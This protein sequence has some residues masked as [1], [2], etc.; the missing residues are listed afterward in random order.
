M[1][2]GINVFITFIFYLTI[3]NNKSYKKLTSKLTF[4]FL[5][6]FLKCG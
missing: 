6:D 5:A 3:Y 1:T 4:I 2:S